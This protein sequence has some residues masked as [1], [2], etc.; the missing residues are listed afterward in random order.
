MGRSQ[1]D[2]TRNHDR[3]VRIAAERFREFG[4]ESLSIA[5]LMKEAGLT[6]GGFYKHFVSRDDLVVQ[7]FAAALGNVEVPVTPERSQKDVRSPV[8]A[9]CSL[10]SSPIRDQVSA[11]SRP[12]LRPDLCNRQCDPPSHAIEAEGRRLNSPSPF[13][14]IS[15]ATGSG[16]NKVS[17]NKTLLRAWLS[18]DTVPP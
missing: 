1:A 12:V 9:T 16:A 13:V 5:N 8:M 15:R 14:A 3:I 4:L 2:K 10:P 17:S 7:A 6:H 11:D 18:R